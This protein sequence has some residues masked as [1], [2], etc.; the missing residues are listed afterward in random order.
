MSSI[1]LNDL[2]KEKEMSCAAL[3][4]RTGIPYHTLLRFKNGKLKRIRYRYLYLIT[5]TLSCTADE[6]FGCTPP[7]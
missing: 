5:E 3:A 2:L 4:R 1:K 7:K 6:L